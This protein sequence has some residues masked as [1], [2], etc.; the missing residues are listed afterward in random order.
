MPLEPLSSLPAHPTARALVASCTLLGVLMAV[1]GAWQWGLIGLLGA[2]V[3]TW[4]LVLAGLLALHRVEERVPARVR[5][6]SSAAL[7]TR[8]RTEF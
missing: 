8:G 2:L 4:A 7:A 5:P 3:S 6:E 1:V